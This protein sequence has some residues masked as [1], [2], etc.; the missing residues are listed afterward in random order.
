M[1]ETMKPPTPT[2]Y[3]NSG[4]VFLCFFSPSTKVSRA[5]KNLPQHWWTIVNRNAGARALSATVFKHTTPSTVNVPLPFLRRITADIRSDW[6]SSVKE[7]RARKAKVPPVQVE[8]VDGFSLDPR[9]WVVPLWACGGLRKNACFWGFDQTEARNSTSTEYCTTRQIQATERADYLRACSRVTESGSSPFSKRESQG[10]QG[11]L[12]QGWIIELS[13][14]PLAVT[15]A[16]SRST[17]VI[18]YIGSKLT[19]F[20]FRLYVSRTRRQVQGQPL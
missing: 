9:S 13:S 5:L 4:E 10:F 3:Q 17:T 16:A 11:H 19:I 7:S 15:W 20:K 2:F 1:I 6:L 8:Q 18:T 12:N 14:M